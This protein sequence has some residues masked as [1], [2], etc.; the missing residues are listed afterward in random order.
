MAVVSSPATL[1]LSQRFP[2][3]RASAAAESATNTFHAVCLSSR[4][5]AVTC[6]DNRGAVSSIPIGSVKYSQRSDTG[7]SGAPAARVKPAAKTVKR[8]NANKTEGCPLFIILLGAMLARHTARHNQKSVSFFCVISFC[9]W[10]SAGSSY[11]AFLECYEQNDY[12]PIGSFALY[13][14][15]FR[16]QDWPQWR[17]VNRDAKVTGFDAPKTWPAQLRQQWKIEVG[18][19]DATPALVGDK[20]YVF[21]REET[22]EVTQCLD[23]AT[24]KQIWMDRYTS[25]PATGPAGQHPGPR[26]SPTV[27]EGKV[28]TLGCAAPCPAW[29][30]PPAR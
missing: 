27:G 4:S 24:G 26:S 29:M 28:V 25:K 14:D 18:N 3:S 13:S 16:A 23:A 21:S 5:F 22:D 8:V 30:P 9:A 2:S 20:L 15:G 19:A 17:G 11:A 6:Q 12:H 10:Q 7:V 1:P